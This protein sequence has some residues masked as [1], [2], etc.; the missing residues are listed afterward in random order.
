[1]KKTWQKQSKYTSSFESAQAAERH[2]RLT[3][4]KYRNGK[5]SITDYNDA[6]NSYLRAESDCLKSK[7]ESVFQTGLLDFYRGVPLSL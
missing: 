1:M 3:E 2:F 6:K 7:C 5:A 4:E